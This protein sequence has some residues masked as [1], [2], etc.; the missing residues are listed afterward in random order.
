MLDSLVSVKINWGG[1]A[2]FMILLYLFFP[3]L[4]W[5]SFLAIIISTHQFLLLFYSIGYVIP[6][7][8]LFGF[9]MC[10]QMFLGPVF[11]YNGLDKFQYAQES[12]Q[13]TQ[14]VYFG[15]VLPLKDCRGKL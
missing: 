7:R 4:S 15:Y 12:M 3:D 6:I 1:F 13:V 5:Y 11:A 8:Y 2:L 14:S 9:L 10:L